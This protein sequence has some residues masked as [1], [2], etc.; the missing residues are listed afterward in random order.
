MNNGIRFRSSRYLIKSLNLNPTTHNR[1]IY[2][3]NSTKNSRT[4]EK[5]DLEYRTKFLNRSF[6]SAKKIRKSLESIQ[7]KKQ[8]IENGQSLFFTQKIRKLRAL[9][10]ITKVEIRFRRA[11]AIIQRIFRGYLVRREHRSLLLKLIKDRLAKG[12]ENLDLKISY[13]W[14]N[15]GVMKDSAVRIQR[16]V[17]TFF[18]KKHEK[19]KEKQEKLKIAN[20]AITIQKWIKKCWSKKKLEMIK[21]LEKIKENLTL[22]KV[23]QWWN[24]RKFNWTA[25]KKHYGLIL[26]DN[27]S[28]YSVVE[29]IVIITPKKSRNVVAKGKFGK[30]PKRPQKAKQRL[31]PKGVKS[32]LVTSNSA[33]SKN[34]ESEKF[35]DSLAVPSTYNDDR[36][37]SRLNTSEN[38]LD[39]G[40]ITP[41]DKI[42]N[43]FKE[44]N[45]DEEAGNELIESFT[46]F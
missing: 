29:K 13:I 34:A 9:N 17:R 42:K 28:T 7:I 5:K 44:I 24:Q 26:E 15:T 27:C 4:V 3:L 46:R 30:K 12:I 35:A 11:A 25:I 37:D 33:C 36:T 21:K 10:N 2:H 23:K 38:L 39:I 45:L 40:R 1:I 16:V 41:I 19:T 14:N 18:Q 31:K 8:E 32:C 20:A 43:L 22:L 6:N